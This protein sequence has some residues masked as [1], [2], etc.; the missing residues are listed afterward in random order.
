MALQPEWIATELADGFDE[1][2]M[3]TKEAEEVRLQAA[4]LMYI[5]DKELRPELEEWRRRA[6]AAE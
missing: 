2:N 1:K 3:D 4:R 6:T 5:Y